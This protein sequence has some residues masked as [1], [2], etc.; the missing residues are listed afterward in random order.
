MKNLDFAEV[1]LWKH[2]ELVFQLWKES[3]DSDEDQHE[4]TV[5]IPNLMKDRNPFKMAY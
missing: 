4:L 2:L 1:L 3:L 5:I